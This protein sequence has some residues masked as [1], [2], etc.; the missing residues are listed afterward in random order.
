MITDVLSRITV[1]RAMILGCILAAFYY[2]MVF[3]PGLAQQQQITTNNT[4]IEQ[5][6][7]LIVENQK[8][9]DRAAVFKKTAS[10]IGSTINKLLSLVPEKFAMPD[11]MRIVSNEAKVAGL[12]LAT[13]APLTTKISDMAPEFEELTVTVDVSGSFLQHMVFLS[14]LTKINQILITKKIDFNHIKDGRGD[15]SPVVTMKLEIIAFRYRGAG[16]TLPAGSPRGKG[17]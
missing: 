12:S 11:L 13:V 14:N 6:Q 5:L 17:R 2:F 4:R 3:D 8:K 7:R 1:V 16:A 10:E 9:L 15:E